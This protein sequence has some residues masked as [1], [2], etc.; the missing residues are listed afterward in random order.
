MQ[1][2]ER[3][4]EGFEALI[5]YSGDGQRRPAHPDVLA[6]L[7]GPVGMVYMLLTQK[8][9]EPGYIGDVL[10]LFPD[11]ILPTPKRPRRDRPRDPV[12][13]E[14]A[15]SP[16]SSPRLLKPA[17]PTPVPCSSDSFLFRGELQEGREPPPPP[18]TP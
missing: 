13:K 3:G 11:N 16:D 14:E 7:R 9:R 8:G 2:W 15:I 12:C 4:H 5:L 18:P 1:G 10:Q 17:P 6:Q